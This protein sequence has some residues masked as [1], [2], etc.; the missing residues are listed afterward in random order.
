[1]GTMSIWH[2]LVF[3]LV[4]LALFWDWRWIYDWYPIGRFVRRTK[5]RRWKIPKFSSRFSSTAEMRELAGKLDDYHLQWAINLSDHTARAKRVIDEELRRRG[6]AS[7]LGEHWLPRKE[8]VTAPEKPPT[9]LDAQQY[10]GRANERQFLIKVLR[11]VAIAALP[12]IPLVVVAYPGGRK[13]TDPNSPILAGAINAGLILMVL[14]LALYVVQTLRS[15]PLRLRITLLRP[16]GRGSISSPLRKLVPNEISHFGPVYTLADKTYERR[17][18]SVVVERFFSNLAF[19]GAFTV[20]ALLR[21]SQRIE[22]IYN[23]RTLLNL[24]RKLP[25]IIGPNNLSFYSAGQALSIKSSN[26]LWRLAVYVLV[27]SN[28]ILVMDLSIIGEGS[29]WELEI[30]QRTGKLDNCIFLAQQEYEQAAHSR[31][32]NY[33]DC[34]FKIHTYDR[35]GRLVNRTEFIIELKKRIALALQFRQQSKQQ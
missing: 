31:V 11:A 14:L 2:W 26:D 20:G 7:S 15:R 30:L 27:S 1:M 21:P 16:F 6:L 25:R 13:L 22:S 28:D 29:A 24:A 35:N 18:I 34:I 5:F 19:V 4:I 9:I 32:A 8:H 12:L 33:A 17:F 23:E 10:I 3:I